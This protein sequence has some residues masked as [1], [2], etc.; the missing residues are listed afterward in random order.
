VAWDIQPGLEA[1][2][3]PPQM[4]IV[5]AN[6]LGNAAKFTR[7]TERPVVGFTG[8]ADDDGMVTLKVADNGA[9]FDDSRAER[10]FQP[11]QRL[12]RQDEYQGTGIGLTIVQR[13]IQR[14]GGQISA[15]GIPGRG[16]TFEFTLGQR[17]R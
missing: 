2:V 12:H 10:L 6:L 14:H 13:I 16:A 5:L 8:V 1:W 11:F 4:R 15:S 9:G 3:S 17:A 7:R